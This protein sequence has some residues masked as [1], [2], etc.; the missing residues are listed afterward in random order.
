M[1]LLLD[2]MYAR[3]IAEGLRA[4]GHDVAAAS[5]RADL[6]S[7]ADAASFEAMQ[8]EGRVIVTNNVR[9]FMPLV[10]QALQAGSACHGVVFTSDKSLPRRQANVGTFVALLD[11]FMTAHAAEAGLPAT[12]GWLTEPSD[13]TI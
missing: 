2:E 1:K 13:A 3:D 7:V 5:E 11:A 4:R 12:I 9:D 8:V 10:Q 6:R